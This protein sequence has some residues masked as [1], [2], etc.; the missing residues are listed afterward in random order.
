MFDFLRNWRQRKIE[1]VEYDRD[2]FR[3]TFDRVPNLAQLGE[4]ER[5]RLLRLTQQ[6]LLE[7]HFVGAHGLEVDL[8]MRTRI[9]QLACWPVLNLGFAQLRG[10]REVIVYPG[11]FRAHRLEV[12]DD[13]GLV[14]Q[15]EEDLAGESWDDGPL[16]ISWEDLETDLDNPDDA[17]NVVV[18][19]IAHKLDARSGI[20]DGAPPLPRHIAPRQWEAD[21]REAYDQL[22]AQ[23]DVDEHTAAI[24]PYAATEPA[25]FFA[26]TSEYHFLAPKALHAAFPKVAVL[27]RAFYAGA[28][29]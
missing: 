2:Y 18:H 13:T 28:E 27:L 9:A 6:F 1:R 21:F 26:V 17:Q 4:I 3:S 14:H 11:G 22:C 16:V 12:D 29:R 5:F 25:E 24:D 8:A 20:S 15:W 10:W 23:V 7:K 19:E